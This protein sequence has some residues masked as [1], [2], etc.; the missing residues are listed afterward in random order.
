MDS[1]Y[2]CVHGFK[3]VKGALTLSKVTNEPGKGDATVAVDSV[4]W[5]VTR[6]INMDIGNSNNSDCGEVVAGEIEVTKKVDGLTPCLNTILFKPQKGRVVDFI[7][8]TPETDGSGIASQRIVTIDDARVVSYE[9]STEGDDEEGYTPVE[10]VRFSYSDIVSTYLS[11]GI[12][13]V[14]PTDA[15]PD[16]VEYNLDEGKLKSGSNIK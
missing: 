3:D 11:T 5:S 4:T 15:A 7:F 14:L 6:T 12:D 13:G 16:I 9:V 2:M 1:L 8:G 10:V